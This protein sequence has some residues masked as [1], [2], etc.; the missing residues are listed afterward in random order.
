MPNHAPIPHVR[1]Q[2]GTT[3][4]RGKKPSVAGPFGVVFQYRTTIELAVDWRKATAI[5]RTQA[6]CCTR[7]Y[8]TTLDERDMMSE[9]LRDRLKF[10]YTP[11]SGYVHLVMYLEPGIVTS[12]LCATQR[13][14]DTPRSRYLEEW[15][16]RLEPTAPNAIHVS[17]LRSFE[18]PRLWEECGLVDSS[19]PS[20]IG[21]DGCVC[22]RP[23]LDPLT[24]MPVVAEHYRTVT[25]NI[26]TWTY[27]TYTPIELSPDER[28]SR[29]IIDRESR[30]FWVRTESGDLHFLPEQ[31]G[32]GFEV[33]Y[34]G[35]GPGELARMIVKL[36]GSDGYEISAG[37]S[38]G[39]RNSLVDDW[40][41]SKQAD[42]TRE[43]TLTD[44]QDLC[45][46]GYLNGR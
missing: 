2:A 16:S 10:H 7:M 21:S 15:K 26:D 27:V 8:S 28:L 1:D 20:A 24:L 4:R 39:D 12:N 29:L 35:G 32:H 46:Y 14:E 41:C 11:S 13:I 25:G 33:G 23:L 22:I 44:L 30:V 40:A 42:R 6:A 19:S 18:A 9:N 38:A 45:R 36:T 43:L 5:P 37:T 17:F 31:T 3:V 34:P